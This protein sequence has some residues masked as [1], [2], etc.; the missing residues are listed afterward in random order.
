MQFSEISVVDLAVGG[1][2]IPVCTDAVSESCYGQLEGFRLEEI[3]PSKTRLVPA[4]GSP[5]SSSSAASRRAFQQMPRALRC[6]V[7]YFANSASIC[8]QAGIVSIA[9]GTPREWRA[10]LIFTPYWRTKRN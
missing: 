7:R 3:A 9:K 8:G 2:N 1:I 5:G 6:R 10:R 4:A